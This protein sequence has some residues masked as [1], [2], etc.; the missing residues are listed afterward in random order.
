MFVIPHPR[1]VEGDGG[2]VWWQVSHKPRPMHREAVF[3]LERQ[4]GRLG[5]DETD[6]SF[7]QRQADRQPAEDEESVDEPGPPPGHGG[8]SGSRRDSRA[9]SGRE[10]TAPRRF[11]AEGTSFPAVAD[12][13]PCP[14]VWS[15]RRYTCGMAL[16]SASRIH[17]CE[18]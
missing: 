9:R 18:K 7:G 12:S 2:A 17:R 16:P 14:S 10:T 15:R 13:L 5:G 8:G 11:R 3:V 4:S 1:R 6:T